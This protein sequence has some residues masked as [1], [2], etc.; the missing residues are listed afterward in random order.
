MRYIVLF[1]SFISCGVYAADMQHFKTFTENLGSVSASFEQIK[2]IPESTKKF[3]STGQVKFEKGTGFIWKQNTPIKQVFISTKTN[4]CI[5]GE[6]TDLDSL[7]YF[8]YIRDM[9]DSALSGDLSDLQTIF[10]LDYSEYEKNK[11]QITAKPRFDSVAEFLQDFVMYGTTKDLTKIIITY[12][13]GTIVIIK[14]NRM[15]TEIK[16][17]IV[18]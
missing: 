11:W 17:E 12:Q 6:S 13:N 7:P 1:L 14:F 15:N 5:D 18:C 10:N 8:Y 16:D 4:Y 2:M 3:I 9:I